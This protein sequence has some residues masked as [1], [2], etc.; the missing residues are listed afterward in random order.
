LRG[1]GFKANCVGYEP[2]L[3]VQTYNTK[4]NWKE[5][6]LI[7]RARNEAKREGITIQEETNISKVGREQ[8]DRVTEQWIAS[9]KVNDREIWLYA[10][11]P[12]YDTEDDVRK[13]VARNKDGQIVGFVFYDP[14]YRDGR[15]IG[16]S[17]N[18]SRCDEKRYGRLAT[19]IHMEAIEVFRGEGVEVLNLCLAPFVK[20]GDGSSMMTLGR[21]SSSK[22][23]S[24]SATTFTTSKGSRFTSR[25]TVARRNR[26]I[27]SPIICSP[28]TTFTS[29]FCAPTLPGATSRPSD[30]WP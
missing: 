7:K 11:R 25:S 27:S 26:S 13:F 30:S 29:R 1:L 12:V 20:L 22:S 5:L 28:A 3:P 16:Y 6:D 2:E 21:V 23:A 4:G 9:K 24:A 18:I 8:F 19:A 10:R 15:V 14:M 17:A